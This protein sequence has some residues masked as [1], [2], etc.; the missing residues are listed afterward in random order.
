ME[1]SIRLSL[2][3]LLTAQFN[4]VAQAEV[5]S[6]GN[7]NRGLEF[8]RYLQQ[9]PNV[10]SLN[11]T[12]IKNEMNKSTRILN[13]KYKLAIK[14]LLLEDLTPSI[15]VFKELTRWPA[16][17]L[18]D[19]KDSKFIAKSHMNLAHLD[20]QN[21]NFWIKH[22]LF[23]RPT[24]RPGD[25][26]F[27][28]V[29]TEALEAERKQMKPYFFSLNLNKIVDSQTITF[30]NGIQADTSTTV[31]PSGKFH[32]TFLKDGYEKKN[33][34]VSGEDSI[35][36]KKVKLAKLPLGTCTKPNF[37]KRYGIQVEKIYFSKNCIR[38]IQD[39]QTNRLVKN[40]LDSSA[41]G[42]DVSSLPTPQKKPKPLFKRRNTWYTIGAG[43]AAGILIATLSSQSS[44]QPEVIPVE[45]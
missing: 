31:H 34:T 11:S 5:F 16:K 14:G 45:L 28:P 40:A 12:Y 30:I 8:Q 37:I 41:P 1:L 23:F 32:F 26:E 21:S 17:N 24:Y 36:L 6:L 35:K 22:A 10:Q 38:S 19:S 9:T 20:K 3:F 33:L 13:S 27:N 29:V 42:E 15:F 4:P 25:N 18:L 39:Q 44:G 2:A 43:V 7:S